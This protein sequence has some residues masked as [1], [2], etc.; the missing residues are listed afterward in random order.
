MNQGVAA[1][2]VADAS[3]APTSR[4]YYEGLL[5][6]EQICLAENLGWKLCVRIDVVSAVARTPSGSITVSYYDGQQ[7]YTMVFASGGSNNGVVCRLQT[8]VGGIDR[9]IDLG[10]NQA[11][12]RSMDRS[13][14]PP[15]AVS[16]SISFGPT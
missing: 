14:P 7:R 4:R 13:I 2:S 10:S 1:W 12:P 11:Q 6:T 15:T 16:L 8:G 5:S 3:T 9:S